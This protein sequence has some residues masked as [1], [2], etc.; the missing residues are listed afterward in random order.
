[1]FGGG[2]KSYLVAGAKSTN[3]V[4]KES[5]EVFVAYNEFEVKKQAEQCGF[6]DYEM[7]L[8]DNEDPQRK[9]S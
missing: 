8:L 3:G 6:V 9:F 5:S 2:L 1:M 7:T 4:K